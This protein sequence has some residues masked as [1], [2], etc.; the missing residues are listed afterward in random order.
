MDEPKNAAENKTRQT[1][2]TWNRVGHKNSK[3]R[4]KPTIYKSARARTRAILISHATRLRQGE[5]HVRP[6]TKGCYRE[7]IPGGPLNCQDS[8][9]N[10]WYA[11]R[12]ASGRDIRAR[13]NFEYTFARG[14]QIFFETLVLVFF[15]RLSWRIHLSEKSC[16]CYY[17][18][19]WSKILPTANRNSHSFVVTIR[20]STLP[21]SLLPFLDIIM[22]IA[23]AAASRHLL[24][25][26]VL[27]QHFYLCHRS[28]WYIRHRRMRIKRSKKRVIHVLRDN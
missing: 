19:W 11:T 14:V 24:L 8:L 16:R 17:S 4:Y 28:A 18:K 15:S 13:R 3:R 23:V 5:A 7:G 20:R 1:C 21:V 27:H 12:R 26:H 10:R 2:Y 22:I 9:E 25:I 6:R